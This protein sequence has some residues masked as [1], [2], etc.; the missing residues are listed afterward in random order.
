MSGI[1]GSA[2]RLARLVDWANLSLFSLNVAWMTIW[3]E[4]GFHFSWPHPH[5]P[6]RILYWLFWMPEPPVV[7]GHVVWSFA[8]VYPF[9][10]FFFCW[11]GLH[12]PI[13]FCAHSPEPLPSW[14]IPFSPCV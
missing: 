4:G 13:S 8:L 12:G 9:F 6:V 2:S 7:L 14:D 10:S 11:R 3:Y 5:W 1:T